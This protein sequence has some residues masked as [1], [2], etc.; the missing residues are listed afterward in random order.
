MKA[1]E[2]RLVEIT[3]CNYCKKEIKGSY[4]TLVGANKKENHYCLRPIKG[5]KE[6]CLVKHVRAQRNKL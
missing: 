1:K 4:S 3:Y 5:D 6:S 2:K